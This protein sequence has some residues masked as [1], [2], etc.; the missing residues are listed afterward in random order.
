MNPLPTAAAR[1]VYL[2]LVMAVACAFVSAA[3][4]QERPFDTTACA[5]TQ[6][7][8]KYNEGLV[9]VEGLITVGPDEFML[10][11]ANCSD[12]TTARFGW[13]SAVVSKAQEA[14]PARI[15]AKNRP[16]TFE[17]LQLPLNKDRDF[18]ALQ[19]LLQEATE[20]RED[21]DAACHT[22]RQS[23][24]PESQP[25]P[26]PASIRAGYGRLS[27]CSLLIIEE[28]GTVEPDIEEPVDFSPVS[29]TESEDTGQRLY[30][31]ELTV[32]PREDEDQLE[33]KSLKDEYQ[34]LHDPK[35]VAARAISVHQQT[36]AEDIEQHLQTDSAT[37]E[38]GVVYLEVDLGRCNH[39]LPR[40][41]QQAVLVD[42]N[43]HQ[44]RRC[45]LGAEIDHQDGMQ[46]CRTHL[47]K[48]LFLISSGD[49]M[50]NGKVTTLTDGIP[51]EGL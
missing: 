49:S 41:G 12:E 32:P 38:L 5:L 16:K 40:R 1:Y 14:R 20:I 4:A 51:R 27:C 13:S 29:K 48:I 24:S 36:S 18:N 30:D 28:V 34:Y 43:C 8:D 10:H 2:L 46:Q 3:S 37:S 44:R 21:Q 9:S 6:H 33:R 26:L 31:R 47:R 45:D 25:Q 17:S 11:D 15:S 39:L 50:A 19:K 22:Y 35:Q 23:I 7:P 42:G